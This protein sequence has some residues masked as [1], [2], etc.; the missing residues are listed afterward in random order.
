MIS[1]LKGIGN[2]DSVG[3]V[4]GNLDGIESVIPQGHIQKAQKRDQGMGASDE[5]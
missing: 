1:G 2:H 4:F 3:G 5:D